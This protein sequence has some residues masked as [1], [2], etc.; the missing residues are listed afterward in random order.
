[1][2]CVLRACAI[3]SFLVLGCARPAADNPAASATAPLSPRTE[4]AIASWNIEWLD[5]ADGR[6]EVPRKPSDYARLAD[7]AREL[8]ADVIALQ[9]IDGEQAARRVFDPALYEFHFSADA[10]T[11]QRTG[12]AWR[13]TVRATPRPDVTGLAVGG[14]RRGADLEVELDGARIRLLSIHLKAGCNDRPLRSREASCAALAAQV[15]ALEDWIEAR[16]R[17]G[18]AFGVLGD[19]NRRFGAHDE[20]WD[21]INDGEPPGS[22]MVNAGH[23]DRI[24]H[25]V[26]GGAATG[27]LVPRSFRRIVY[28]AEDARRGIKLSDHSP[29][30]VTLVRATVAPAPRPGS[31]AMLRAEEARDHVGEEATV[32]GVVASAR[33]VDARSGGQ[34]FLNLDRPHPSQPFTVFIRPGDRA[35]FD[36]PE[37]AFARKRICVT[38]T[39]EAHEG[40]PQ[41]VAR[42]P[43]QIVL[44]P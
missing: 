5:R 17:E 4:L 19:F 18:V 30:V 12:F 35:R 6:G 13:K 16:A 37:I 8:D 22:Q 31:P 36:R 9:E 10:R 2:L 40:K 33:H 23:V 11:S 42:D 44:A 21:A 15:P 38:G 43:S 29:I 39:I 32:C 24:D 25:I 1:M 7:Y 27:W 14:L 34:T 26:L 41:I 3:A 28:S 20:L